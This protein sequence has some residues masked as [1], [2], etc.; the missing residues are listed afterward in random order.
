MRLWRKYWVVDSWEGPRHLPVSS[1]FA[2]HEADIWGYEETE[3]YS[4]K[5]A[6]FAEY[7]FGIERT[8]NYHRFLVA[9]LAGTKDILSI[10]SGRCANELKLTDLGYS[11]TCTDLG[12]LPALDATR[13]LFSGFTH[14]NLDILEA[15]SV[16]KYDAVLTL[17][18][19]YIFTQ[20]ELRLFF[21][22]AHQSLRPGGT[23]ILD[24]PGATD[25]ALTFLIDEVVLKAEAVAVWYSS[26]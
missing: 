10:A 12:P 8:S 25:N 24:G 5:D 22:N 14:L 26:R 1:T 17:G 9:Q 15:P 18:L 4:S 19:I 6:F 16:D 11:V 2:E 23:L 21:R 20:D 7:L 3:A 13:S